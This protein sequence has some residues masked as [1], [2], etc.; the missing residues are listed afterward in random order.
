MAVAIVIALPLR[1][2]RPGRTL[3]DRNDASLPVRAVLKKEPQRHLR[4]R[5]KMRRAKRATTGGQNRGPI[6][7][8]PISDRPA[9]AADRAAPGHWEGD[10]I[11]G[12]GNSHIATLAN[13]PRASRFWSR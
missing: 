4:S 7:A 10:L 6:I 8:I 1:I 3:R 2:R 11:A 12:S 13:V 9:D 5:R